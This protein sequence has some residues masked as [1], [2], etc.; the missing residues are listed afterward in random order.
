MAMNTYSD[1][2][3]TASGPTMFQITN[4]NGIQFK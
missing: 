2:G 3:D 4:R 1:F